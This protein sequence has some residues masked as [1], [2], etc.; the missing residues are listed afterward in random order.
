MPKICQVLKS[1]TEKLQKAGIESANLDAEVLLLNCIEANGRESQREKTRSF[2]YTHPEFELTKKQIAKYKKFISRRAK[3]EPVAY[4]LG[5]KEFYGLDFIVN[6][7]VLIPRPETEMMVDEILNQVQDDKNKKNILID[8]GTGSAC[9]PISILKNL[10]ITAVATDFST[11]AL[12][13]AKKNARLHKVNKK[14]KFIKSDL[15]SFCHPERSASRRRVEGSP[16]ASPC[17]VWRAGLRLSKKE[18][19]RDS[20]TS[21]LPANW[22]DRA[23]GR[24]DKRIIIT[25]NLPYLSEK[26][27]S[28]N[29][30]QLKFEPRQALVAKNNGLAFYEKLLKQIKQLTINNQ[31]LTIFLEILP[32]QKPLLQ[33][34][35]KK[36]L[37]EANV[38][39]KKDLSGQWRMAIIE[40]KV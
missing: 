25:A 16:P 3:G 36:H 12:A 17:E 19:V 4:I 10:H 23:F 8:I 11:K 32:F 15:L 20:S 7:N 2:L 1:G 22:A 29:Y 26:I 40:I 14:I 5:H 24:N 13:V 35:I 28:Q 21:A 38:E 39:F 18:R 30:A 31:R 34:I 27:Y 6:K 37:P 9:I 33:K